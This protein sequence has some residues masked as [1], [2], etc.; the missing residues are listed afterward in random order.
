MEVVPGTDELD[1]CR[2]PA[3]TGTGRR[4]VVAIPFNERFNKVT[5]TVKLVTM[6]VL[7]TV[8]IILVALN[9]QGKVSVNLIFRDVELW[10][11][12]I[13]IVSFGLGMLFTLLLVLIRKARKR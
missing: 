2:H 12:L 10:P 9:C 4:E 1:R 8:L 13:I 3:L 7:I 6:V 11:S 5:D